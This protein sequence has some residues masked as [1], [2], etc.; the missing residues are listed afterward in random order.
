ML[1]VMKNPAGVLLPHTLSN[2]IRGCFSFETV[3]ARQG[4]EWRKAY[5]KRECASIAS[6][7]R[8]GWKIVPVELHEV[9]K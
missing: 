4:E 5:W 8:L 9:T 2:T 7:K 6:A 1:Y 3:A